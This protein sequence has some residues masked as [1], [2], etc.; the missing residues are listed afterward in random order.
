MGMLNIFEYF[1]LYQS[2]NTKDPTLFLDFPGT[3]SNWSESGCS[4]TCGDGDTVSSRTCDGQYCIGESTMTDSGSP[5]NSQT[6][7]GIQ[8]LSKLKDYKDLT[9]ECL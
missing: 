6:C 1:S 5:C 9:K 3:W 8:K 2:L 7:P 4:V